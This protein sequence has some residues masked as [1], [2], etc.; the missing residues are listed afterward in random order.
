MSSIGRDDSEAVV[1]GDVSDDDLVAFGA[2]VGVAAP[3][4]HDSILAVQSWHQVTLHVH[5]GA[6]WACVPKWGD[7]GTE[8]ATYFTLFIKKSFAKNIPIDY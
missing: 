1:V 8:L 4:D 2:N 3:L 7:V 5:L 6:V